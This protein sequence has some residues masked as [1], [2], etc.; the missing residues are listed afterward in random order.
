MVGELTNPLVLPPDVLSAVS[1]MRDVQPALALA[2]LQSPISKERTEDDLDLHRIRHDAPEHALRMLPHI[3]Y[4]GPRLLP[5]LGRRGRLRALAQRFGHEL[6]SAR[7]HPSLERQRPIH[8]GC[9]SIR[10]RVTIE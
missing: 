1:V 5:S 6:G 4:V 3:S 7:V 10:E 8:E 2:A 9:E